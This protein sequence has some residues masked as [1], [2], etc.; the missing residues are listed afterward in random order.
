MVYLAERELPSEQGRS[1]DLHRHRAQREPVGT[2]HGAVRGAISANASLSPSA[3][4]H[5]HCACRAKGELPSAS[6]NNAETTPTDVT[7]SRPSE[8]N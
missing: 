3:F 7:S 1:P 5:A 2:T 6:T 8:E 4:S